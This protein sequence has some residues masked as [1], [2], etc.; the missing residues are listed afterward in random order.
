VSNWEPPQYDPAAH[1]R[2]LD[3]GVPPQGYPP[4]PG[5]GWPQQRQFPPP[6]PQPGQW[7]P[8]PQYG[9]PGPRGPQRPRR[10]K[11]TARNVL[12]SAGGVL[13]LLVIVI[14]ATSHGTAA[15]PTASAGTS[16]PAASAP[17]S[18]HPKASAPAR[19]ATAPKA[20]TVAVP[21]SPTVTY[22]V[23]GS[24]ADVIYGPA[25][26]DS[27]GTVP[28]HVTATI[29]SSAPAYYAISAQLQGSG[30][31]SCEILVSGKVISQATANGSFNI[32]QCEI[33]QDPF[34]GNWEDTNSA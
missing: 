21:A 7:Q 24:P 23:S 8:Q 22:V 3:D 14:A 16:A 1:Q 5:P 12:L 15:T 10:K 19:K 11:H 25:G 26:S 20:T 28:M 6:G 31:V 27:Q 30:S 4:Q 34:T 18:G 13:V 17:A 9:P 33:D 32:A 29:P 2:R